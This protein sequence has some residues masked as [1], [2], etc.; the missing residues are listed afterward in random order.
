MMKKLK[1][2]TVLR[3]SADHLA[4]K[5]PDSYELGNCA[6]RAVAGL[7]HRKT[8]LMGAGGQGSLDHNGE[9][10]WVINDDLNLPHLVFDKLS[11]IEAVPNI[12][13]R[14]ARMSELAD[15]F[16]ALPGGFGTFYEVMEALTWSQLGLHHKPIGFLNIA[17]YYHPLIRLIDHAIECGFIYPEHLGL[18]VESGDPAQLLVIMDSFVTPPNMS[19]WLTRQ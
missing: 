16:I 12:Q 17:G 14:Q 6:C 5:Y 15:G 10:H 18:F 2:I 7:W 1:T 9:D 3:G 11:K 19:R 13:V 8:G 4:D